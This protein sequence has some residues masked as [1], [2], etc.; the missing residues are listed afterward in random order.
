MDAK[1]QPQA[2]SFSQI[3]DTL[4]GDASGT[5]KKAVL[6]SLTTE[7]SK[8]KVKLNQGVNPEEHTK[9][10]SALK[11]IKEAQNVVETAWDYFHKAK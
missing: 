1:N 4:M 6:E 3:E 10:E 7:A 2:V 9:I 8:L 5:K 11:A